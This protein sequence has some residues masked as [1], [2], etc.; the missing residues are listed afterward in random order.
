MPGIRRANIVLP[1]PGG[2]G[3]VM[4]ICSSSRRKRASHQ[5]EHGGTGQD[6]T[7]ASNRDAAPISRYL[8]SRQEQVMPAPRFV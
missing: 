5:R 7:I 8:Q 3:Y 4:V 2:Q 6:T 1:A